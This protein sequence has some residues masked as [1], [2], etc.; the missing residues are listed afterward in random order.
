MRAERIAG[1]LGLGAAGLFLASSIPGR[2]L[3][4]VQDDHA[5]MLRSLGVAWMCACLVL[6]SLWQRQRTG[7]DTRDHRRLIPF[8]LLAVAAASLLEIGTV[9]FG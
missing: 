2:A 1:L 8:I 4:N 9:L 3:L 7:G 6:L 5:G